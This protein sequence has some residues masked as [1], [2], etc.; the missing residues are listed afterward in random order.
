MLGQRPVPV[1]GQRRADDASRVDPT[2]DLVDGDV[3]HPDRRRRTGVSDQD[4]NDPPDTMAADFTS[5]FTVSRRLHGG[6]HGADPRH[7]GRRGTSRARRRHQ[8][9]T[10]GVVVGDYEG[11][12]PA[13]RGFYL[14]DPAG[15]ADPT[16]SDGIFVFNGNNANSVSL[17]D[18]VRVPGTVGEFQGQTQVSAAP[19]TVA[20]CGTGTV[21]PT[22]VDAARWPAPPTSS[23]TRACSSPRRSRC[24]SPSTSSSAAS[25]RCVVVQRWPAPA[26][27]ERRRPGRRRRSPSRPQNNLNR[28]IV[29]DAS[30][31]QNPDPIL[32]GRGGDAAHGGEHAAR[33]RHCSPRPS[34]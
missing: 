27:D 10:R 7:P 23:S 12:S 32:F 17:G 24:T 14:Q 33:R 18:V 6:R 34:A 9:T 26:A 11:P 25:A 8:V 3:L 28:L 5:T 13:L 2:A 4:T 29:D 15:D 31:A 16:T 20:V 21:E 22:D 30:Q 19:P 1:D